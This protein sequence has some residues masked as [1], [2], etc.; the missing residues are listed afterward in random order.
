[1]THHSRHNDTEVRARALA[2]WENEGGALAT[3]GTPNSL[4]ETQVRI[5]ASLGAAVLDEWGSLS[6]T[7]Q[8]NLVRRARTLGAPEDRARVKELLAHFL[9]EHGKEF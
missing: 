9:H 7:V 3:A 8:G 6:P 2:R 4:D 1:M 5:L